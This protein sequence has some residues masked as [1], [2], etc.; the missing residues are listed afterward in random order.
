MRDIIGTWRLVATRSTNDAGEPF[1]PPYGP[2]PMGTVTFGSNGRMIAVLCDSRP[3][4]PA[5]ETREYVSYCGAY[6]FDGTTLVTKVDAA[7]DSSR[8]VDQVRRVAFKG[9]RMTLFPPPRPLRGTHQ[10]REMT[11]EKLG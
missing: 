7:S 9:E 4:M 1:D 10:H 8:F 3:E 5:G 11:W 6:T 2:V